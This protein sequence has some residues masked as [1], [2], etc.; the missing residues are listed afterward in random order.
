VARNKSFEQV[1]AIDDRAG[2]LPAWALPTNQY[3]A[4]DDLRL[5]AQNPMTGA[6]SPPGSVSTATR[7]MTVNEASTLLRVSAKTIRRL[8]E[9]GELPPVRIGRS[10]RL[11][12]TD[13]L[14][15]IEHGQ[16][17]G[18]YRYGTRYYTWYWTAL[19][20]NVC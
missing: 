7:L 3:A 6:P 15:I 10:V 16:W 11:R 13:V 14:R 18:E 9:R 19:V 4:A 2:N 20:H 1:S 8:I 12:P 5:R 17:A